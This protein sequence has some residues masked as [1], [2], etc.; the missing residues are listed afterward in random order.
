MADKEVS[1]TVKVKDA[2]SAALKSIENAAS[3]VTSKL[4][5]LRS[6]L[7]PLAALAAGFTFA[8]LFKG[9]IEQA[10]QF[11]EAMSRLR[12]AVTNVG[13]DFGKMKPNIDAVV[14]GLAKTTTFKDDDL[15]SALGTLVRTSGDAG[16]S[17]KTLGL[18]ADVAAAQHMDLESAARLVG[19]VMTGNTSMLKRY[20]ISVKEGDD[21]LAVMQE[22]MGGFAANEAS[23]LFGQLTKIKNGFEQF[24]QAVGMAITGTAGFKDGAS[25]LVTALADME[26]WVRNNEEAIG[27]IG[28]ALGTVV[29]VLS[30]AFVGAVETATVVLKGWKLLLDTVTGTILMFAT[31]TEQGFGKA[32]QVVGE[33]FSEVSPLF[34]KFGI[35]LDAMGEKIANF[36][37]KLQAQAISARGNIRSLVKDEADALAAYMAGLGQPN[38]SAP[39]KTTTLP[40]PGPTPPSDATLKAWQ[41]LREELTKL[42][43]T[44]EQAQPKS[45]AFAQSIDAWREKAEKAKLPTAEIAAGVAKLTAVLATMRAEEQQ[46]FNLDLLNRIASYTGSGV[47]ALQKALADLV[48]QAKDA[49][50]SNNPLVLQLETLMH[51]AVDAQGA[52]E[53]IDKQLADFRKT[54]GMDDGSNG[55]FSTKSLQDEL[56]TLADMSSE[57]LTQ[58]DLAA[59][60]PGNEATV[61]KVE[62]EIAKIEKTRADLLKQHDTLIKDATAH[63][64]TMRQ[65]I[66]A[67][68]GGVSDLASAAYGIVQAFGQANSEVGKVISSVSQLSSGIEKA[69]SGWSSLGAI[70]QLGAIGGIVGGAIGLISAI[71]QPSAQEQQ[72]IQ[73]L[74]DNTAA[75]QKLTEKVG[76]IGTNLPANIAA[77]AAAATHQI[78]D[79]IP[80]ASSSGYLDSEKVKA[81][82]FGITQAQI[83]AMNDAAKALGI[84]ID[85]TVGSYKALAAAL[86][87]SVTKLGEFGTDFD[88]V[89]AQFDAF[90]KIFGVSN[91]A[92]D[93]QHLIGAVTGLSPALTKLLSGFDASD[94]A[95]LDALRKRIQ[96]LFT[97][98]EAGGS[99]LSAADLG[100]LNG[101]QLLQILEHLIT[102]LNGMA[103]AA[104]AAASATQAA[105]DA[106]AAAAAAAKQ[107]ALDAAVGAAQT[108]ATVFGQSAGAAAQGEASAYGLDLSRYDLT[109]PQGVNDAISYLQTVYTQNKGDKNTVAAVL[110]LLG[111]LRSIQFPTEAAGGASAAV[112]KASLAGSTQAYAAVSSVV[113]DRSALMLVDINRQQLT[114]AN[115]QLAELR[116]LTGGGTT[117]PAGV[118][119]HIAPVFNFGKDYTR[120]AANQIKREVEDD[121]DKALGSKLNLQ[122]IFSGSV[123]RQ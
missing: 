30:M 95:S 11:E 98:M 7:E 85:G 17:V 4:L 32:A 101:D 82:Y 25:T 91:P 84:T 106:Q 119:I 68:A 78:I 34:D 9:A 77:T 113:T 63:T 36:G 52:V 45:V 92:D 61:K 46:T 62:D 44:T 2:G 37:T 24:L 100:S 38:P 96:D 79:K 71:T 118:N 15:V 22:R 72:R 109:S 13:G 39:T 1:F 12:L 105:A 87:N 58:R 67:A 59:A 40:K 16:A 94:P 8:S 117:G 35:H 81:G 14:D 60:I 107:A 89:M 3:G 111:L 49:G 50:Q 122:H 110:D 104:S 114:V 66:A 19:M 51:S 121:L 120:D 74:K 123:A 55:L 97:E 20:G 31:F 93:L 28:T 29:Q 54:A 116:R 80:G 86:D 48:K 88:S 64:E 33:W 69:A 56:S 21:A 115:A 73:T 103:D 10:G 43:Q 5:S 26:Q 65:K 42:S 76:L 57:L 83:N 102:D 112:S 108:D 47:A 53:G 27:T 18:A 90:N 70:G 41:S 75:I 99:A 23:T 6:I